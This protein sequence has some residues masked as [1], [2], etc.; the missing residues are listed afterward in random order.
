MNLRSS[1]LLTLFLFLFKISISQI[2]DFKLYTEDNGLAQNY[3]YSISQS[4]EGFLYLSTGDGFVSFGGNKFKTFTTKDGLNENFVNNH[5]IDSKKTIW[6]GHY[7]SGI[8]YLKGTTFKNVKNSENLGSKI[9]SFAEDSRNNIWVVA[10][11]KGVFYIDSSH[12]LQGPV[13]SEEE[14]INSI[15]FDSQGHL[16]CASAQGLT[17]YEITNIKQPKLLSKSAELENKDIKN[18]IRDANN[19][20]LYWLSVPGDGVYAVKIEKNK[21]KL[22]TS[23]TA[24]LESESKNI[25]SLFSDHESNLWISLANEGLKKIVFPPGK[26]KKHYSIKTI[27]KENGLQSNYIQYIFEDFEYNMWFGTF[28]NGLIEMPTYKFN[29]F[30]PEAAS[31]IQSILID[32][33]QYIWLGTK[34][35]ILKYYPEDKKST[36]LYDE[37]NGFEKEQVNSI[38]KDKSG[39]IWIGSETKGVFTFNPQT[40]KF[41][42]FSKKNSLLNLSINYIT[43]SKN[44]N[45]IIA[46]NDGVYFINSKTN[47]I[48]LLTTSEGLLHN[49]VRQI[50]CDSKNR[51]WFCSDG[52]PPYFLLNDEI[53]VLR[54][55]KEL[56]SY[57]INSVSEDLNGLI[58]ICTNG[59]GVFS[60]DGKKTINLRVEN[61]LTSN[62]CYSAIVNTNNDIWITHKNGLSRIKG[63][64][65]NVLSYKKSDGLLFIKN[66]LNAAFSDLKGNLWFGNEE[67]LVQYNSKRNNI[68]I[69]EAKMHV[70]LLTINGQYYARNE[71]I[72]LPYNS[73][74]A[75]IDYIGIA[76]ADPSKVM[77]KYRLLGV[78]SVWRY[79]SDR[80]LE[81]PKIA[82]GIYTFQIFACNSFGI[83]TSKAAELSFEIESPFW[84]KVWFW[85]VFML[86]FGSFIYLFV[87]SRINGLLKIQQQLEKNVKEKTYQLQIEKEQLENVKTI[88]EE[89]S[90]DITASITYA[91]HIQESLLPSQES[92]TKNFPQSFLFFKPRD[93]VSGDFYWFAET[94]DSY[95]IAIVDCTGHGIPG[96]FM[97]IIGSLI[98]TD[99]VN[100]KKITSPGKILKQLND[101]IIKMLKQDIEGSSSRDGMDVSICCINKLKTKMSYSSASRPMYYCRNGELT[102]VNLKN[103]S[104]GGSYED[105]DKS[106]SEIEIDI[107]PNDV[108]FLFTDGYA[109]QFDQFDKKK[110]SSKR[111]KQMFI[112]ISTLNAVEQYK[113]VDSTFEEWKGK[114]SQID[115]VT[116]IGFKV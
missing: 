19:F 10:Q 30:K 4:S 72:K 111:L 45:I 42:N 67:G 89:K 103:F 97:S 7:Q 2:Y 40:E 98:L 13:F 14:N 75:R 11:G 112:D 77:Y 90:K 49:N 84:K 60:Y 94:E 69:P 108:F 73:Y 50:F 58:W 31:D 101:N 25:L 8:S 114:R 36:K 15:K 99:I 55:I 32:S 70:L 80:V 74:T 20:T 57:S 34:V 46:T 62:F 107:D 54:D 43:E 91:K 63:S 104:I 17:L 21:L 9:I 5:F 35:G 18:L 116:I 41:E 16:L 115:D 59:D 83:W 96:A 86:F 28:G 102:E 47:A 1:F 37:S 52:T 100:D 68:L 3:I 61:G 26:D 12:T 79:T 38:Y 29:F 6:L 110:F 93:I 23:I 33:S 87:R 64:N 76:L 65:H 78:D 81:F 44:G 66:N 24:D 56:K 88:L 22:I 95:V 39:K 109:D 85:V 82:D 48:E 113:M 105:Y 27:A 51:I 53:T 106:F 92:F 71:L